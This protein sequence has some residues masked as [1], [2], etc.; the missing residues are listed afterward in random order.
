MLGELPPALSAAAETDITRK[1][2]PKKVTPKPKTDEQL[3]AANRKKAFTAGQAKVRKTIERVVCLES[4]LGYIY[5]RTVPAILAT[6]LSHAFLRQAYC[7]T[8]LCP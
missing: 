8:C 6:Y 5:A 7:A 3:A 1:K 4:N 2:N